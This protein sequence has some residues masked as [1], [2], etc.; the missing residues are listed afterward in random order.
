MH[1]SSPDLPAVDTS[2]NET[3]VTV[4]GLGDLFT[5]NVAS[6]R[7]GFNL[8]LT[9]DGK[10]ILRGNYGRAHRPIFFNEFENVHPGNSPTTLARFN[11]A[12]GGYTTIVSVTDP[13]A[14][15]R[16]DNDL[17]SP[18]TDMYSVGVDRELRANLGVTATYVHKYGQKQVGWVDIGGVYGTRVDVLPDGRTITVYPLL[19]ATG[20]RIFLRTNGPGFFNRYN[21]L[22]L[23]V[24][25]R[26]ARKW[27]TNVSYT[28]SKAEGLT[29]G[30]TTGQDPNDYINLSGR[31]SPQDRPHMFMASA[32][33]EVPRVAV[34]IGA[35][36]Q[37]M[38]GTPFAPQTQITLPQGRR[39]INIA[40]PDGT[41][42]LD[43]QQLLHLRFSKI[44]SWKAARF[45]LIAQIQNVL[46]NKADLGVTT[47]NFFASTFAQPTQ[48]IE[49][50][51]LYFSARVA[52]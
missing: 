46:Q 2:L 40:P 37:G 38:S 29:T 22:L 41:Y 18:F 3:G 32:T 10:T 49:P 8:K 13:I 17:Q 24:N 52:F 34:F 48:W 43:Q 50:R 25:K 44:L 1:A 26:M 23:G 47:Q 14:N 5:W 11:A 7:L 9:N 31:L 12:T 6:P 20:S 28:Y 36:Y 45:E 16:F 33:Y 39:T 51:Q 42:R 15:L 21:G 30:G 4:K 27:Q 19:N 35:N